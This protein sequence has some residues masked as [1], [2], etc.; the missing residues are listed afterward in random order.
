MFM[1]DS[2]DDGDLSEG[3]RKQAATINAAMLPRPP[4]QVSLSSSPTTG[5]RNRDLQSD[6]GS[7]V[8]GRTLR[9]I[10]DPDNPLTAP[11]RRTLRRF[12]EFSPKGVVT[13]YR[14]CNGRDSDCGVFSVKK[15]SSKM[16]GSKGDAMTSFRSNGDNDNSNFDNTTRADNN[17]FTQTFSGGVASSSLK[18]CNDSNYGGSSEE[19]EDDET[20]EQMLTNKPSVIPN[21]RLA[22]N[23]VTNVFGPNNNHGAPEERISILQHCLGALSTSSLTPNVQRVCCDAL[24]YRHHQLSEMR[25]SDVPNGSAT[26]KLIAAIPFGGVAS[27]PTSSPKSSVNNRQ[28]TS[29]NSFR[30][31]P[32]TIAK[33]W[34]GECDLSS[35]AVVSDEI[36]FVGEAANSTMATPITT[37][38]RLLN[39]PPISPNSSPSSNL[40]RQ[41]SFADLSHLG[42]VTS[43]S[44]TTGPSSFFGPTTHGTNNNNPGNLL[45]SHSSPSS[46]SQ[47][48]SP[49]TSG[50]SHSPMA[51][52]ELPMTSE[53]FKGISRCQVC[54]KKFDG[55]LLSVFT[56]K[57][58][59]CGSCG[60]VVCENK[61]CREVVRTLVSLP[62]HLK[63][64][65]GYTSPALRPEGSPQAQNLRVHTDPASPSTMSVGPPTSTEG[66]PNRPPFP[67]SY[68]IAPTILLA[69]ANVR[70]LRNGMVA[71]YMCN[72]CM[73]GQ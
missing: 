4:S 55:A 15:F 22:I 5:I 2:S 72:G 16:I 54:S 30:A 3:D 43:P 59:Q 41:S 48:A 36:L 62:P 40:N 63:R 18:V 53:R 45:T 37:S 61:C 26:P 17:D 68:E 49:P 27:A 29:S 33:F 46:T 66:S 10:D 51:L 25:S 24:G 71:L 19:G 28:L 31:P 52:R 14:S 56:G 73:L 42:V 8:E 11:T 64:T 44:P 38:N 34:C 69:E 7:D 23:P 1:K 35:P 12:K 21:A 65:L 6:G 70:R 32:V 9:P 13:T 67:T 20:L 60:K 47:L 50:N 57:K 39:G 58:C